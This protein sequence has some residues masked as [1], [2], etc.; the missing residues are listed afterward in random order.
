[1]ALTAR[2]THQRLIVDWEGYLNLPSE[3]THYEIIDG[4]VKPLASPTLKHQKIVRQFIRLLDPMIQQ[5]RLGELLSAP[6]DFVVRR[7]PV[8]TRQP[9]LFFLS[10]GRFSEFAQLDHE[11]RLEQAPD[12]IIEVLSPSDTYSVW[13]EKLHDY[14]AIGTPEVW[15]VDAERREIEVLVYEEG[16]YRTLGWFSGEQ[17]VR[18]M[19]LHEVELTPAAVFRVLDEAPEQ[20]V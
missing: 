16:G 12:L 3:L 20:S 19:V 6:F 15:A 17:P 8:R 10:K 7:E 1:M 2:G 18:S 11:S 13:A 4:E 5:R 9:D 14:H